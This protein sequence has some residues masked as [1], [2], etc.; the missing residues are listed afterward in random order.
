MAATTVNIVLNGLPASAIVLNPAE[1]LLYVLRNQ[2]DQCGPKF[3][4]GIAQCGSCTVLINGGIVRSCVTPCSAVAS[5]AEVTTLDGL[6]KN[7]GKPNEKLHPLQT[8]FIAE[9]AAQCAFCMNGMIMG[10]KGWIDKRIAN[11][12]KAVP[13]E[14]E[15]KRFLSGKSA[16]ST[17]VYICRCGAHTRI[18]RAIQRAAQEMAQ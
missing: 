13:T 11:G 1:P 12:N 3:G 9:Q 6:T 18:V 10:A 16:E 15:I 14:D 5:G 4:C 2:L 8:A 7:V 17:L